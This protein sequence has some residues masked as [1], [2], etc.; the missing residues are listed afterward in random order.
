MM[1]VIIGL[2]IFILGAYLYFRIIRRDKVGV[3]K[4]NAGFKIRRNLF[5]YTL[6]LGGFIMFVR[7]LIIWLTS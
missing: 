6:I 3:H 2:L 5:I 1:M 4:F 7:E